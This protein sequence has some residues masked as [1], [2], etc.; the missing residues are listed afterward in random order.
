MQYTERRERH[1]HYVIN[2]LWKQFNQRI[3]FTPKSTRYLKFI[4]MILRNIKDNNSLFFNTGIQ[5]LHYPY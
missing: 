1:K 2:I 5:F 3:V 4:S